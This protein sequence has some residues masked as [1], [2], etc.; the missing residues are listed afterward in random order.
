MPRKAR[1][2]VTAVA[3]GVG[4]SITATPLL[5]QRGA[6]IDSSPAAV[7]KIQTL[8]TQ[9]KGT[10][11]TI[12]EISVHA[13]DASGKTMRVASTTTNIVGQ[14]SDPEDIAAISENVKKIANDGS[15]VDVTMPLVNT[16]GQAIA[17][18]GVKVNNGGKIPPAK[19][20]AEDVAQK[21]QAALR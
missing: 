7:Q 16:K 15:V 3:L 17:A 2:L 10:D 11:P 14:P 5:A 9:L 1:V 19:K 18:A 4:L 13:N 20:I 6:T 12:Q 8:I 21:I